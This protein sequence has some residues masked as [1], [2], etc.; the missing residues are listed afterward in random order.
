MEIVEGLRDGGLFV[1]N[2]NCR[3]LILPFQNDGQGKIVDMN[4]EV[5]KVYILEEWQNL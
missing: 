2:I 5:I 4:E 1:I 3:K